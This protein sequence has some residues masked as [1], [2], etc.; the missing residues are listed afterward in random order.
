MHG[1]NAAATVRVVAPA[2]LHDAVRGARHAGSTN[3]ATVLSVHTGSC[4][5]NTR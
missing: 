2:G 3:T 1:Q 4:V 5:I